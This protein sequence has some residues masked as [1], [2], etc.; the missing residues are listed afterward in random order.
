MHGVR[1]TACEEHNTMHAPRIRGVALP[2][3]VRIPSL[4]SPDAL[5]FF[6][7]AVVIEV[8]QRKVTRPGLKPGISGSGGRRS[9]GVRSE[10]RFPLAGAMLFCFACAR[11]RA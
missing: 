4:S 2:A 9:S 10:M 5:L 11:S 3:R 8:L 7:V 6:S 1:R